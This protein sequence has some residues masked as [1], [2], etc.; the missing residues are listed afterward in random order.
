MKCLLFSTKKKWAS[1]PWKDMGEP[2]MPVATWK[3]P[4]LDDYVLWEEAWRWRADLNLYKGADAAVKCTICFLPLKNFNKFSVWQV[5][6]PRGFGYGIVGLHKGECDPQPERT[7]HGWSGS[8]GSHCTARYPGPLLTQ[9]LQN[10]F[11]RPQTEWNDPTQDYY[12]CQ[13]KS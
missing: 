5:L 13:I 4:A 12:E 6:E 3:R 11:R 1:K 9:L 8:P 10:Y 2:Q 7:G